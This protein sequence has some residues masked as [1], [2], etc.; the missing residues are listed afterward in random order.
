MQWAFPYLYVLHFNTWRYFEQLFARCFHC[1]PYY[2]VLSLGIHSTA[3]TL[4]IMGILS[5]SQVFS[6]H[7]DFSLSC[8]LNFHV[9][10]PSSHRLQ[11]AACELTVTTAKTSLFLKVSYSSV[12]TEWSRMKSVSLG[13]HGHCLLFIYTLIKL[14]PDYNYR[15]SLWNFYSTSGK[16]CQCQMDKVRIALLYMTEIGPWV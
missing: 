5:G 10:V 7:L 4:G 16:K 15:P 9:W 1:S 6:A 11:P 8:L 14:V 13:Q 2:A 3:A 12:V